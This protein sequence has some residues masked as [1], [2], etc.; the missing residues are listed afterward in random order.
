MSL[1]ALFTPQGAADAISLQEVA[2]ETAT[3]VGPT[4]VCAGMLTAAITKC[5][6]IHIYKD[7]QQI[8]LQ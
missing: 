1:L 5:T 8:S 4:K 3:L 6:L 2:R 7:K